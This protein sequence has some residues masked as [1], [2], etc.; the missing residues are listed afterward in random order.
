M[1]KEEWGHLSLS[2]SLMLQLVT[3]GSVFTTFVPTPCHPLRKRAAFKSMI[4]FAGKLWGGGQ[5]VWGAL[6]L[7]LCA[8]MR[9]ECSEPGS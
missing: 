5:P 7:P 4:L 8:L 2:F 6:E 1:L 3:L 9:L